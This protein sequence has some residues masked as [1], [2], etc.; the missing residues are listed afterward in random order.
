M[1][2]VRP[3]PTTRLMEAAN[4][5]AWNRKFSKALRTPAARR[6]LKDRAP[7]EGGCWVVGVALQKWLGGELRVVWGAPEMMSEL[8][9]HV[10]VEVGGLYFDGDGG[11]TED[12]IEDKASDE[13]WPF[14]YIGGFNS[15]A[16][17]R[18]GT[19]RP[20]RSGVD[21]LLRIFRKVGRPPGLRESRV[22]VPVPATRLILIE[23]DPGANGLDP[24]D[25]LDPLTVADV[26]Q[27]LRGPPRG[28]LLDEGKA[29]GTAQ[30]KAGV[31][32]R[33]LPLRFVNAAT[34]RQA[35]RRASSNAPRALQRVYMEARLA[36]PPIVMRLADGRLSLGDAQLR[37][38]VAIRR[39]YERMRLIGRRASGLRELGADEAVFREEEKWFRSAVREELRYWNTF[40]QEVAAGRARRIPARINAYI[41]ALRFMYEAS[42]IA[43]M[44][45][46]TLLHWVGPRDEKLCPGCAYLMEMS[47]FVKDNIPAVPRDG[48]TSCLTH[49]RHRIVVRV[50]NDLSEVVRRRQQLPRRDEMVRELKRRQARG[51]RA[52]ARPANTQARNPF[53]RD[54]L[55][56]R[57]S[58]PL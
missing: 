34:V 23:G 19:K 53:T 35:I 12:A 31:G 44:P 40:L 36:L 24:F 18:V 58:R 17:A 46:N 13:G 27:V 16:L 20:W 52:L 4:L 15:A 37:S 22:V 54:P 57:V 2:E 39:L 45:D 38:A 14:D 9:Q 28:E 10:V 33:D 25:G 48:S 43:A 7:T 47:P 11:Q 56:R 1:P 49:C 21:G 51:G 8:A 55:T 26:C 32:D 5:S 42:R 30:L 41:D 50:A 6:A 29:I 3:V